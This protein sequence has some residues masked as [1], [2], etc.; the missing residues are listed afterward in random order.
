MQSV[1]I[2]SSWQDNSVEKVTSP[3]FISATVLKAVNWLSTWGKWVSISTTRGLFE[4]FNDLEMWTM[5][6]RCRTILLGM[7]IVSGNFIMDCKDGNNPQEHHGKKIM[8]ARDSKSW[9]WFIDLLQCWSRSLFI[10][11]VENLTLSKCCSYY[12][13]MLFIGHSDLN[14]LYGNLPGVWWC[15]PACLI[16]CINMYTKLVLCHSVPR[17]WSPYWLLPGL[18]IRCS[19]LTADSPLSSQLSDTALTKTHF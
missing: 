7:N 10:D 6:Q 2:S 1:A 8:C 16:L 14:V 12:Y 13:C 18:Y 17:C 15:P 3:F 4:S 5:I 9:K 19:E 11:T